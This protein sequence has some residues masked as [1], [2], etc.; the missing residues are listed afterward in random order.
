MYEEPNGVAYFRV[1]RSGK[2]QSLPLEDLSVEEL[3]SISRFD[4][5]AVGC[6]EYLNE[7]IRFL[8]SVLEA[9]GLKLVDEGD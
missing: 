8:S 1:R 4:P 6:I 9:E 7:K 2:Y 5:F 3:R